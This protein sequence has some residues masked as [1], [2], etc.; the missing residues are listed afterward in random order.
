MSPP[1]ESEREIIELTLTKKFKKALE[2]AA[3]NRGLTLNEYL[4]EIV[5]D[6]VAERQARVPEVVPAP[7]ASPMAEPESIVLSARDW[8]T[9]ISAIASPP[10]L[11]PKLS[12]AIKK[13]KSQYKQS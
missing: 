9:V 2:N 8:D 3:A 11:N 7:P 4:L 12:G 5:L 6:A 13:Y 10:E 1:T